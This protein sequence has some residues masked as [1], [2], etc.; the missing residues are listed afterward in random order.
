ML[1]NQFLFN[2]WKLRNH[3]FFQLT[4]IEYVHIGELINKEYGVDIQY[5]MQDY[6]YY[7][8]FFI[9]IGIINIVTGFFTA[10]LIS[11]TGCVITS[12]FRRWIIILCV[13]I[14][15]LK[16]VLWIR[17]SCIGNYMTFR[18]FETSNHIKISNEYTHIQ[19]NET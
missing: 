5:F 6:Y 17:I 2:T 11:L 13:S 9:A 14:F 3:F 7:S 1:I 19:T 12:I 8:N 15:L 4:G 16:Y 10:V 18:T